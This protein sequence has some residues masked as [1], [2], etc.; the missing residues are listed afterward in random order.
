MKD[1]CD[2]ECLSWIS[3]RIKQYYNNRGILSWQ[4]TCKGLETTDSKIKARSCTAE[5]TKTNRT[6]A[7]NVGSSAEKRYMFRQCFQISGWACSRVNQDFGNHLAIHDDTFTDWLWMTWFY[8]TS[9]HQDLKALFLYKTLIARVSDEPVGFPTLI[10]MYA[11]SILLRPNYEYYWEQNSAKL[12]KSRKRHLTSLFV[13]HIFQH[14]A[15]VLDK[16]RKI[17]SKHSNV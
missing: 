8:S 6:S 11:R 2:C 10:L 15:K 5:F 4:L 12:F 16:Y 17:Y 13:I 1:M 9:T 14:T 7:I 3:K